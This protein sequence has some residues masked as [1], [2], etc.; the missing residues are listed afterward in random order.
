MY[1]LCSEITIGD[2]LL[3]TVNSVEVQRSLYNITAT[4]KIKVPVTAVL[5][6]EN[7]QT[8]TETAKE[9]AIGDKVIIKLGYDSRMYTEFVGY[10]RRL[11]YTAPLEIICEDEF[12]KTRFTQV[13]FSGSTTLKALLEKCGLTVGYATEFT[14]AQYES[15]NRS[16]NQILKD[17]ATRY[18]LN[19]WFDI[20]GK[21]YAHAINE[22]VSEIVKYKLRYN[23]INDDDLTYHYASD[24]KIKIKAKCINRDGTEVEATVGS[25]GG[26]ERT[27]YFYDVESE[28]ELLA[29]ANGE[30]LR[31]SYDGYSGSITTFLE[32]PCQPTYVAE[33]EDDVYPT[34]NGSYLIE[35]VTTTYSRSGA[36]RVVEIGIKI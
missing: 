28:S 31:R 22:V 25:E 7:V 6:H 36:R 18:S 26:D 13:Q 27:V 5:K 23:V 3:S 20:E 34:R 33:I 15:R 24:V 9:I 12:Y 19:I 1:V 32:P 17:L 2:K 35:G 14:I 11:N 21:V 8:I 4:A 10:V 29:L 16:A 30:L